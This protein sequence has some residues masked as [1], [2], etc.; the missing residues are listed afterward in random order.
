MPAIEFTSWFGDLLMQLGQSRQRQLVWIEG[1]R[2]WCDARVADLRELYPD[3]PMLSS[4]R[5]LPAA[6][7]F[8]SADFLLGSEHAGLVFDG[9]RGFDPDALCIAAGTLAAG[10]V[11]VILAPAAADRDPADDD[12][13][14][15]Q[16]DLR[17]PRLRFAEYLEASITED[18]R[19][20]LCITPDAE[21]P[22]I[23]SLPQ[24]EVTPVRNG[25]T[26]EQRGALRVIESWLE[27]GED[28]LVLLDADRG[29]GKSTCLGLLLQAHGCPPDW[30]VCAASR[31]AARVL[32]DTAGDARF[33]A[34]DRLLDEL[35]PAGLLL[36]DEAA[37]IPQALLLQLCRRYPRVILAT[38][39]GGYEGT[40]RGFRLRFV[41]RLKDR[42]LLRLSL[43]RPVR[44]CHG[45]LLE[46]WIAK[47]LLPDSLPPASLAGGGFRVVQIE[48][49]G[50][51]ARRAQL[52]ELYAL[53]GEAHYRTRPSDLRQLMENPALVVFA[54][55][56]ADR[57]VGAILL[58][59]EG[60][61]EAGLATEIF[62]GR[63]RPRGHLLAQMLTAQ[64]G[65]RGFARYR[66]L[67][68]Q[69]IAVAAACRR[70]GVGR[71]LIERACEYARGQPLD[72]LGAS[73]A[74]D[75]DTAGFWQA[76][77][78]TFVHASY[79]AGKSSGDHSLALLLPLQASLR[80]LI[81]GLCERRCAQ[82][83]MELTQ[84]LRRLEHRQV[85]ALLR[86]AGFAFR[87]SRLERDDLDAFVH[88]ERGFDLCFASL[89]PQVMHAIAQ[90]K[91]EV[92]ALL[93]E[94]AVQNRPWRLLPR[95]SGADGRRQLQQRLRRLVDDLVN[96]C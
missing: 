40:G 8:E 91:D 52:R 73:F 17:S 76:A 79:A 31:E 77:G 84:R 13:A 68:V 20:G 32:L 11:L 39:S 74:L 57:I 25:S 61:F 21:L 12:F 62:Y 81:L 10:G 2:D 14:L 46:A 15:W 53:L 58:N 3:W 96:P 34:P 36:V 71:A 89:Q 63:R 80:E 51:P 64:A 60:G 66:G 29:R 47:T 43:E 6:R 48:E 87:P 26:D 27:S 56:S 94:K 93:V 30:I 37:M 88:G 38:T 82:L 72:Y 49:P 7:A 90:A 18:A 69:R 83:P 92:P 35:P 42:P 54:A 33:V 78:F 50:H 28:G 16:D 59:P 55:I 4:R 75:A 70:R 41:D 9:W 1:P 22:P 95:D 19:L 86:L 23:P 45:D 5:D 24:L 67:R 85:V 65:L 44:W